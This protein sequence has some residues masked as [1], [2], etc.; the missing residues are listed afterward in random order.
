MH[1]RTARQLGG[2]IRSRRRKLGWSQEVLATKVGVSRRWVVTV[3]Q[4]KPGAEIA[5]LLRTMNVLGLVVDVIEAPVAR[6]P[7]D[8]D[9]LLDD[10]GSN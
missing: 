7:T 1:V 4:G 3:E 5:L 6:G 2:A 10:H 8:L 9:R